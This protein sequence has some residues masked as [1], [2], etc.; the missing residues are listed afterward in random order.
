MSSGQK[1]KVRVKGMAGLGLRIRVRVMV[2]IR[3]KGMVRLGQWVGASASF[4]D[5]LELRVGL[6]LGSRFISC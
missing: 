6:K 1:V 4:R 3:V 2:R 5:Q